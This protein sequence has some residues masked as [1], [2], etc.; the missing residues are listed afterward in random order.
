[1]GAEGGK[2]GQPGPPAH[3]LQEGT[4][5]AQRAAAEDRQ[6]GHRLLREISDLIAKAGQS[7]TATQG[8]AAEIQPESQCSFRE[9]AGLD[10]GGSET[11]QGDRSGA[12]EPMEVGPSSQAQPVTSL[13]EAVGQPDRPLATQPALGHGRLMTPDSDALDVPAPAGEVDR[14]TL[15]ASVNGSGSHREPSRSRPAAAANAENEPL[16]ANEPRFLLS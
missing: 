15:S 13:T 12:P 9:D 5:S 4:D 10:Q 1:M 16:P 3:S 14:T 6:E 11:I 2:L 7:G 8:P